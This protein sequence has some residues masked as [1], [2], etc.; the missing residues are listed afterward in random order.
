[1]TKAGFSSGCSSSTFFGLFQWLIEDSIRS[2]I[3]LTAPGRVLREDLREDLRE[4]VGELEGFQE[5]HAGR[6]APAIYEG[7]CVTARFGSPSAV[8]LS[9]DGPKLPRSDEA[10]I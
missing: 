5:R 9:F 3:S 4:E 1:V 7:I 6:R 8:N 2:M 10:K